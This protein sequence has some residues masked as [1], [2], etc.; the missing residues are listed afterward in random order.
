MGRR[1]RDELLTATAPGRSPGS[2]V[3][4]RTSA[5]ATVSATATSWSGR[6]HALTH[7]RPCRI[8]HVPGAPARGRTP[9]RTAPSRVNT[10]DPRS[11]ARCS[12]FPNQRRPDA[13]AVHWV[14]DY[15]GR[16]AQLAGHSTA[17]SAEV[18]PDLAEPLRGTTRVVGRASVAGVP[19]SVRPGW[20][21]ATRLPPGSGTAQGLTFPSPLGSPRDAVYD[22]LRRRRPFDAASPTRAEAQTQRSCITT[23]YATSSLER[24]PQEMTDPPCA[25]TRPSRRFFASSRD[26][27]VL[28][29]RLS[30]HGP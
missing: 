2:R 18:A 21:G 9:V 14:I 3:R 23:T 13:V 4:C 20:P 29:S 15:Y 22:G 26:G 11:H 10:L 5:G 17:P 24:L 6:R 1:Y 12:R 28:T 25:T 7:C 16:A 19:S 30:S 27:A 8:V